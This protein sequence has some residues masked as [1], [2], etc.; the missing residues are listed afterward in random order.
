MPIMSAV[1]EVTGIFI[2]KVVGTLTHDD[3]LTAQRA[4]YLDDQID[5]RRPVLWDARE[6]EVASLVTFNE[7][8]RMAKGANEFAERMAG[9]RTAILT[10]TAASFGMGRMYETLASS[11][12][13]EISVFREYEEAIGWLLETRA[14][15][16]D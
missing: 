13:R 14:A 2:H 11:L 12:P 10:A 4:F 6:I 9:G 15:S 5:H 8:A 16:P 1:D 3:V 7:M